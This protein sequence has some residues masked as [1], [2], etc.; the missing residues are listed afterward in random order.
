MHVFVIGAS[1]YVGSA[2]VRALQNH[3]HAVSGSARSDDAAKKLRAAGVESVTGDIT[4]PE[5]LVAPARRSDG[6]IYA[7]QYGGDDP[8]RVEGT[9]LRAL[10]DALAGSD[11][12]LLYTSGIWV[13]G[14]TN[15]RT[16]DEDAALNPTPL[17]A[18]RPQLERA[19]LDG[20]ARG[21]RAV[22]V[23]PGD[24][25]GGGGGLPAM[26]VR[27]A[28][29]MG[30][31]RFV[32]DGTNHWPVVERDDLARLFALAIANAAPGAIYNAGDETSFTVHEMAEAASHGAGRNGAVVSWPLEEARRALGP[33]AD[34]LALDSRISSRRAREQLGWRTT[35]RSI[36]DDLRRGSYAGG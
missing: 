30:A 26:W 20:V 34:A 27:S 7:V 33:F 17:V 24:V 16:V 6:V 28:R 5:S 14:D 15:G 3:G 18:H 21:V 35:S 19:V 1:G 10:V 23:R 11:K 13:Y 2:I 12:T 32:G 8:A 22:A 25:Y 36:L 31:A 29:E 9:A 4:Q